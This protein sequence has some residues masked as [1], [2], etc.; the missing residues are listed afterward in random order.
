[1][2]HVAVFE[3]GPL[4]NKTLAVKDAELV[5]EA[6]RLVGK[7]STGELN[8]ETAVYLRS[9]KPLSDGPNDKRWKYTYAGARPDTPELDDAALDEFD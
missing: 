2:T 8:V 3:G 7:L 9:Q 1:M 4:H 5:M 6:K